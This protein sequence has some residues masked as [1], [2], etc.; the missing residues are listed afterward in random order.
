M[1]HTTLYFIKILFKKGDILRIK[2]TIVFETTSVILLNV[3]E[4][5]IFF[6]F[7]KKFFLDFEKNNGNQRLP[8]SYLLELIVIGEWKQAESPENFDL[9]KGF[10]HV[11]TAIT[12]YTRMRLV[13]TQNYTVHQCQY[14]HK[15]YLL[16]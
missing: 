9:R 11:L 13:S 15:I 10:Y 8:S 6:Y 2:M 16:Y 4:N 7:Q 5:G 14:L 12:N 1:L 3:S